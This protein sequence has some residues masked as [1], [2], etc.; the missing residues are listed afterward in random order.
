MTP[1]K[2]L[3]RSRGSTF[4]RNLVHK[5][6]L[7][8]FSFVREHYRKYDQ[9]TLIKAFENQQKILHAKDYPKSYVAQRFKSFNSSSRRW[10]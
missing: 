9:S 8:P 3:Y 6:I 4:R 10:G 2:L 1:E 7:V 5:G